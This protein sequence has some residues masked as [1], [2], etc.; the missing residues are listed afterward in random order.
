MSQTCNYR[1]SLNQ[2]LVAPTG[3][4]TCSN[5][6]LDAPVVCKVALNVHNHVG[7]ITDLGV[8]NQCCCPTIAVSRKS[9]STSNPYSSRLGK[10]KIA[11]TNRAK[12]RLEASERLIIA[13]VDDADV[14]ALADELL[15]PHALLAFLH[16][17]IHQDT[18]HRAA[19]GMQLEAHWARLAGH[20]FEPRHAPTHPLNHLFI[21]DDQPAWRD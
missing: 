1:H 20:H 5:H 8:R 12:P 15:R 2:S 21:D 17:E 11:A 16:L 6:S 4:A 19:N 18:A 3:S 14:S 7:Q 9:Q 10:Q 13:L